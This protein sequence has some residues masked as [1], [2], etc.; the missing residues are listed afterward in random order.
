VRVRGKRKK[1]SN[2][3]K[4]NEAWENCIACF[5]VMRLSEKRKIRKDNCAQT[6]E[7]APS[8]VEP[9]KRGFRLFQLESLLREGSH[10][11]KKACR[12]RNPC[13]DS[14]KVSQWGTRSEGWREFEKFELTPRGFFY[15]KAE[16]A[17]MGRASIPFTSKGQKSGLL[18]RAKSHLKFVGRKRVSDRTW[19]RQTIRAFA[20]TRSASRRLGSV[21]VQT[22]LLRAATH[23]RK[24]GWKKHGAQIETVSKSFSTAYVRDGASSSSVHRDCA[25]TRKGEMEIWCGGNSKFR[26]GKKS[27]ARRDIPLWEEGKLVGFLKA[28]CGPASKVWNENKRPGRG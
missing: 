5:R 16:G 1:C 3:K 9:A 6:G 23:Q 13:S 11:E 20:A 28:W 24:K 4:C 18:R 14:E 2:A 8:K 25:R 26:K 27:K 15:E 17:R 12:G 21:V 10:P 22:P 7:R 19:R